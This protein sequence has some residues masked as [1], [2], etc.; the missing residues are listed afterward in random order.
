MEMTN[1][2]PTP[3]RGLTRLDTLPLDVLEV[4]LAFLS[5]DELA[6]V[7][8]VSARF[9]ETAYPILYR[10]LVLGVHLPTFQA[11]V[12]GL[13]PLEHIHSLHVD[14]HDPS[15]CTAALFSSDSSSPA[16]TPISDG[17]ASS[18]IPLL[19]LPATAHP[20]IRQTC[21]LTH[22]RPSTLVI[23][24]APLLY[25]RVTYSFHS[26]C[27]PRAIIA[28]T[29]DSAVVGSNFKYEVAP[30]GPNGFLRRIPNAEEVV[31]VFAAKRWRPSPRP[32]NTAANDPHLAHLQS[33][34]GGEGGAEGDEK[35]KEER[36]YLARTWVG[37]LF[38]AQVLEA[39]KRRCPA[40]GRLT[41]VN[42]E[43]L[44]PV[45]VV[46]N[47]PGDVG[48]VVR[49]WIGR[50]VRRMDGWSLDGPGCTV[51]GE[52]G[53]VVVR[54]LTLGEFEDEEQVRGSADGGVRREEVET[55]FEG[56]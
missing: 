51:G 6:T 40:L 47:G 42:L 8:R 27:V 14:Q 32:R 25:V 16:G 45:A 44:D 10:H 22:L 31:W 7:L 39:V 34:K 56:E 33:G 38:S 24:A 35:E 36:A 4:I 48:R 9:L 43:A 53:E 18:G 19:S 55:W 28:F 5:R 21:P 20:N 52:D 46:Q 29:P 26:L 1:H 13:N 12:R 41:I 17:T 3:R 15:E 37:R 30:D 50:V 2:D 49:D 23:R 54:C 11:G